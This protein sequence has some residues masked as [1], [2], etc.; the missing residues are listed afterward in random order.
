[1]PNLTALKIKTKTLAA[2]S[3][4]I[5]LEECKWL[6]QAQKARLKQK[7][8][9]AS[10]A[11]TKFNHLYRHRKDVVRP[12]A[13]ACNIARAFIVGKSFEQVERSWYEAGYATCGSSPGA[14]WDALWAEVIRLVRKFGAA[15][16]L[17]TKMDDTSLAMAITS[18][19]DAHPLIAK[20]MKHGMPLPDHK[21]RKSRGPDYKRRTKEEWEKMTFER[22]SS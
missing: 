17:I 18:W 11:V 9:K 14:G 22:A 7:A 21:R 12:A 15:T 5:R 20:G 6:S 10:N 16:E 3:A 2:E 19:R 13:R 1:M 4:F 8:E